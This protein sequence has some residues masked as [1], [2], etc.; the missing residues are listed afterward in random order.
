MPGA[1]LGF[2]HSITTK[3]GD[4]AGTGKAGLKGWNQTT[5]QVLVEQQFYAMASRTS[6]DSRLAAQTRQAWMSVRVNSG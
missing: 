2:V 4:L 3:S 1:G 5:G 6:C